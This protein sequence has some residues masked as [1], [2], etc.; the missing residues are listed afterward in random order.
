MRKFY[1]LF[2][3]IGQQSTCSST[4]NKKIKLLNIYILITF[5]FVLIMP[6]GDTIIGIIS[7][8]ILICYLLLSIMMFFI[9]LLN[10]FHYYNLAAI[11][12]LTTVLFCVFMFSVVLLPESYS[13]Y[14]YVFVPGIALTLFNK[15]TIPAVITLLSLFLFF[16]P[17]YI[18]VVYP[19]SV[20]EK[21]DVFAVFGLFACV[22][23]LVNYFKKI[24]LDNEKKLL[25]AYKR[26]EE[27][28][29]GELAYLQL[30]SLKGKMN[31]HFIFNTMNS[32]QN[33]VI[34]GNTKQTYNYLSKLSGFIRDNISTSDESYIDFEVEF[35][36]LK[37]Y[38]ELEK[39]RFRDDF[40]YTLE[41]EA[42][43]R[44][45]RIPT[46]VVQPFIE[47]AI[48]RLFHKVDG[49]KKIAITFSQTEVLTCIITD[50]GLGVNEIESIPVEK[51]QYFSEDKIK[52]LLELLKEYHQINISYEYELGTHNKCIIKIPYKIL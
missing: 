22:Y 37:K 23:L 39:L 48:Q 29:K 21:I 50:N 8:E 17:Y 34:K 25:L 6:I 42:A 24:N 26:L 13:E 5:H 46:L 20:V 30:K 19:I 9:L 4:E 11:G 35:S 18:I 47:N 27:T 12:W 28:Q 15:N 38:L 14:Y 44:S 51:D 7:S 2:L 31:P 49:V 10:K 43:I 40:E 41:K 36:L 32:I 16:I 52:E 1:Q 45:L 3:E 33:F